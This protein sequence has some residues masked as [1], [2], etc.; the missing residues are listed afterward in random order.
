MRKSVGSVVLV[1]VVAAC[2]RAG[3]ERDRA[4]GVSAVVEPPAPAAV[5]AP[6][7]AEPSP[8]EKV[9]AK[10]TL[11]EAIAQLGSEMTDTYNEVS[12]G[13]LMLAVWSANRL[14]WRDV[15]VAKNE[16][17]IAL[18]RKDSD[19]SRGKRMCASGR[20]IQ[21][22]KS[23]VADTKLFSG[24]M[25]TSSGDII[26]FIAVKSTGALVEQSRARLCGV[27]TGTYD[28]QNS[29]GG[30]GHAVSLSGCST[31]PRTISD[32]RVVSP[33]APGRRFAVVVDELLWRAVPANTITGGR[34]VSRSS[35]FGGG[36]NGRSVMWRFNPWEA[37][38]S[39][40]V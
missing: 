11:A 10:P 16:T 15:G 31:S 36:A 17:S 13:G 24:L 22:A 37:P 2:S 7:P 35:F 28:Y 33:R 40:S 4:P 18:V 26:H 9:L 29:G 38:Q 21:I 20:I 12:P 32:H 23:D 19:A 1:V 8:L 27:V 30:T 39:L 6:K 3:E 5:E 14:A 34:T 25:F